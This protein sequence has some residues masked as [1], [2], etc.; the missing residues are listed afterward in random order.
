MMRRRDFFACCGAGL[1]GAS[2]HRSL[3]LAADAHGAALLSPS[4]AHFEPK[5]KHLLFLFLTGGVSHV[6]TFD[7]KP[8]LRD[9]AGKIVDSISLRDTNK[10]PLLP[11]PFE[12]RRHGESG[13]WMSELF[14]HLGTV[15]DELCVIRT[16]HTDIVEHFQAVLA[17]HTGSATVPLP[18]VGAWLSYGLG[19]ENGNLPGYMVL[20]E[21]LPYAGAQNWDSHFLPPVHQG[22]R[23][24]PGSE[25]IPNLTSR[26]RS[27]TLQELEQLMLRDANEL[28]AGLRPGDQNLTA[29]SR[30]FRTAVGM[31]RAAPEAFDLARETAATLDE[32]GAAAGDTKSF[33]AQCLTARRLIERGVRTVEIID[34]GASNNWDS[35]GNMEDHRPKAQRV[36]RPL[37]ALIR[38]L[39]RRGLLE[40][41]LVAVCTEFGRTPWTDAPGTRGRNHYAKAF[42]S[43]L[44]GAGVKGGVAY[45]ETDEYGIEIVDR[46]CHVHDYHATILHLMGIDHERLTY[47]YAGRDFRLTDVHGRVLEEILA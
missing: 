47:R 21:H 25:P 5:A 28:H 1:A 14:P 40:E 43:L 15:A 33:A 3:S 41:T 34:T 37:A 45:G 38:D 10:L 26:S 18:S 24:V 27:A 2:L 16:L 31:M 9:D 22:V 19:T 4:A 46:P 6:D 13:L 44:C 29:R 42:S 20:C 35:H 39:K 7:Y 30:S 32:Y 17:M 8:K 12:F 23:I 11:S 36:D